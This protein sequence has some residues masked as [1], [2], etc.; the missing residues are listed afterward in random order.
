MGMYAFNKKLGENWEKHFQIGSYTGTLAMPVNAALESTDISLYEGRKYSK[1]D[2]KVIL[3][4][5]KKLLEKQH[6]DLDAT[7]IRARRF[8]KFLKKSIDGGGFEIY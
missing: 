1:R 7:R 2:C 5:C 8:I 6:D 3:R 4:A